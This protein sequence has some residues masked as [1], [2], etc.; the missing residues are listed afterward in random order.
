L[1]IAGGA[2]A[3]ANGPALHQTASGGTLSVSA[4]RT[5]ARKLEAKQ[6][7]QRSLIFTELGRAHRRS[8][9]R[10]DF[11]YRDRSTSNVLCTARIVVV[12]SGSSR[13]ASLT[14]GSCHGI[15]SDSLK[16][17]KASRSLAHSVAALAHAVRK[18]QR[19]YRRSLAKC[20]GLAIPLRHRHQVHLLFGVGARQAFY[21]PLRD[22]LGRFATT[23]HDVQAGDPVLARGSE[24][25]DRTL[26]VLDEI[27]PVAANPCPAVRKWSRNGFS[28]SS[29]PADFGQLQ[30]IRDTLTT[31]HRKLDE[32]AKHLS[33]AGVV[34]HA[35][36]A[37]SPTGL[38]VLVAR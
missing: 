32:T 17:E 37:F 33:E 13:S 26:A 25:W 35:A 10:I 38:R 4:A 11:P 31:E 16:F 28:S 23:L 21:T 15:P 27:P 8:S 3:A 5:L 6:R 9:Q 2:Q 34:K 7:R 20:D 30:V 18:S 12:Q 29:A 22:R 1:C 24:A 19:H 36:A 14:H